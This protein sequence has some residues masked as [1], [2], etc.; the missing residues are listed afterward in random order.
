MGCRHRTGDDE[1]EDMADESVIARLHPTLN[2]MAVVTAA[3]ARAASKSDAG[4]LFFLDDRIVHVSSAN[5]MCGL[6]KLNI[7][8]GRIAHMILAKTRR[9]CAEYLCVRE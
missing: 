3:A 1:D 2:H 7:K 9:V 4:A 5:M 8:S 6:G